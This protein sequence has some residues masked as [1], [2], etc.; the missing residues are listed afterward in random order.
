LAVAVVNPRQA[1]DL[2]KSMGC[3]AKTDAVDARM[4]AEFRHLACAV[5]A[6][7]CDDAPP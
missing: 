3:L 4:L 7:T 6:V 1:R 5:A 2:A